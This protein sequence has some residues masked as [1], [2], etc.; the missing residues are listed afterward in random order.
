MTSLVLANYNLTLEHSFRKS[1]DQSALS[2][3]DFRYKESITVCITCES[4]HHAET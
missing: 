3:I 4:N 2:F 1:P